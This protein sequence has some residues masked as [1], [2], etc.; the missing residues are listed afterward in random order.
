MSRKLPIIVLL[1]TVMLDSIGVGIIMPVMP[2]L[3]L[4]LG[5]TNLSEAA[6]LGG[7]LASIFAVVQFLF[8]PFLGNLSDRFGRRPVLLISLAAMSVDYV[9]MGFAHAFW[10]LV[11]GRILGG[12]T[13]ATPSTANAYMADIS[14]PGKKAQNFGLVGAAFGVGFILGPLIGGVLGEFGPRVPFFGAAILAA[15]NA[16]L[17]Y[18]VLGETLKKENRRAF[19]WRRANPM[20]ALKYIGRLPGLKR[21][22]AVF[23][24]YNVAFFVY[25]SIWAYYTQERYG[26]EP[27]ITGLSLAGF[28]VFVAL[29][30]GGLIRLIIPKL[31]EFRT[32]VFGMSVGTLALI[33]YSMANQGWQI[34]ALIPVTSI[35]VVAGPALQ[36]IMSHAAPDDQQGELQ[37]L[38]LSIS[39]VGMIISPLLMNGTF[40]FFTYERAPVY[41]PGAPFLLAAGLVAVSLSVFISSL[42]NL[43]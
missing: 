10:V 11:V 38:L 9:I 7:L 13:S 14:P 31:G 30:Q 8:G 4:E 37:G 23:F 35:G 40:R 18:F 32:V 21:L 33:A 17:G 43:R 36:G 2:S 19:D 24:V 27:S 22:L 39:S 1:V 20:G 41:L 5:A 3:M 12:I 42:K 29:A 28:G 25:P 6:V 34:F 26:W 15:A 16:V